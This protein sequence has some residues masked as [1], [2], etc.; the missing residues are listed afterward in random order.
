MVEIFGFEIKRRKPEEGY[1][2]FA[3]PTNDD[4]SLTVAEG[5]VYGTYL[6]LNG[7]VRTEAELI[8]KYRQIAQDP[9]VDQAITDIV[10]ESIVEDS[11]DETISLNLEKIKDLPESIKKKAQDEFKELLSLLRF[12]NESYDIFKRWYIDGRLYYHVIIDEKKEREGIKEL[13]YIDP[14][15]IKKVK[16]VKQEY[17]ENRVPVMKVIDEYYVYNTSGFAKKGGGYSINTPPNVEG[18]KVAKDSIVFCSSGL[19]DSENQMVLSHLHKALRPLN[20]LKSMDIVMNFLS[21]R[22]SPVV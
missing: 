17:T 22:I 7:S 19:M 9:T 21:S 10:D 5:G 15:H 8:N 1:V 12:N 13:R 11:E 16:Q 2:S 20:M 4:G 3:P 6:D 18:V 14:R